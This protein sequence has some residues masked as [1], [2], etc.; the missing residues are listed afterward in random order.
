LPLKTSALPSW[1]AMRRS[2]LYFAMR[3][4]RQAEPVLI[5]PAFVATARSAMKVSSVSPE[6]CEMI[7][8]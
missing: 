6:R 4:V 3:S 1:L 8:V 7:V 2:W 5:S